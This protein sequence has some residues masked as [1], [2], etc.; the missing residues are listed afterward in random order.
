[1]RKEAWEQVAITSESPIIGIPVETGND[2]GWASDYIEA[3]HIHGG[4]VA[5]LTD[6]YVPDG[7]HGIVLRGGADIDPIYYEEEHSHL[8]GFTN[9]Q[10]DE[11]E[12]KIGKR[13]LE[14]NIPL[15]GVCRGHQMLNVLDG[16]SLYQDLSLRNKAHG[17]VSLNQITP[18]MMTLA[19]LKRAVSGE[20]HTGGSHTCY[21]ERPYVL[22]GRTRKFKVNSYH[23]QA[24]KK[25]GENLIVL[26][27]SKMGVVEMIMMNQNVH[28]FA[29]G[30]QFHP[31]MM[32]SSKV[33]SKIW[34]SFIKAAKT[35]KETI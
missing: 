22:L 9:P 27:R 2:I 6:H 17:T 16:G 8:L 21:L 19:G 12:Y 23:H 32:T 7:I 5:I 29:L 33:A 18:E 34:Q 15:L 25:L 10:R 26:G 28:P 31:E 3:V 4:R 24:V 30:C 35:Y 1:M 20:K 13:A 14:D 11:Q